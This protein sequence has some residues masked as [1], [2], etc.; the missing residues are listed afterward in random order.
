MRLAGNP[1]KPSPPPKPARPKKPGRLVLK[2]TSAGAVLHLRWG[3][4]G[5]R[6]IGCLYVSNAPILD[7]ILAN[8][9]RLDVD[10]LRRLQ[11]IDKGWG[12]MRWRF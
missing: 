9:H 1:P 12:R 7:C 10:D 6:Y 3:D 4:Q 8:L 2:K 11:L 5:E